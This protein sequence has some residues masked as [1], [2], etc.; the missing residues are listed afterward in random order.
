MNRINHVTPI[1]T[2]PIAS[3]PICYAAVSE[4]AV[5]LQGDLEAGFRLYGQTPGGSEASSANLTQMLL[6]FAMTWNMAEDASEARR[7]MH[8]F[9]RRL[10]EALADQRAPT[11]PVN[12]VLGRA[13]DALE[14]VFRSLDASFARRQTESELRYQL[15]PCPLH[16]AA[17]VA[18]MEGEAELAHY[19]LNAICQSVVEALAPELHIQL[20]DGPDVEQVISVVPLTGHRR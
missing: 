4:R 13:A 6:E 20:P 12:G 2:Y 14:D 15:D 1:F 19:A 18:T 5:Y 10:G 17:Q 9:G 3:G 8:I 11:K 7:Q 16:A